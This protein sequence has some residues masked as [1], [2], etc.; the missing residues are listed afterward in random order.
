L[1]Q[2]FFLWLMEK[3][4]LKKYEPARGGFRA[5]L[6]TVLRNFVANQEEAMRCL[7]RGGGVGIFS[8][9]DDKSF[10]FD[11]PDQLK[12]TDPEKVFDRGWMIELVN[13]AYEKIRKRHESRGRKNLFRLYDEYEL[14]QRDRRPTYDELAKRFDLTIKKVEHALA[15]VREELRMEIR[16]EL[17]DTV[18]NDTELEDEWNALFES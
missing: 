15:G 16:N 12:A 6:K 4:T 1:S 8:I 17:S 9:H 13:R 2:A 7:K 14:T 10:S 5:Y 11:V 18:S 3:D